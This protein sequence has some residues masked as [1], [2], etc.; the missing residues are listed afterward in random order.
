V[1]WHVLPRKA[2]ST[3][4][5]ARRELGQTILGLTNAGSA[6]SE[7]DYFSLTGKSP[8]IPNSELP[9]PGDGF[10]VIDIHQVGVRH[11]PAEIYGD[12]YL[13]FAISSFSRRTHPNFPAEFDIGIDT[14]DDGD[15]DFVVF[16]TDLGGFTTG[17]LTGQ[18]VV[19]VAD[20][21]TGLATPVFFTDADLNSRNVIMT[22]TLSD[23]GVEPGT[24]LAFD[25]Y[26]F[27]NYF[28]GFLTDVLGG[29]RYTPGSPRYSVGDFPFGEVPAGG[30]LDIPLT[31]AKVARD[32]SSEIGALLMYRRNTPSEN[33]S[34]VRGQ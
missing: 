3:S 22:L 33:Q 4:L 30:A 32:L 28:T 16:N 8:R 15:Y 10:A 2:A 25:V 14:N 31:K 19:V 24:T 29:M 20:L 18:N 26:A 13:E 9:G 23:L 7:F 6:T 21:T 1:P 17:T 11:L 34:I 27:D 5:R 12:D